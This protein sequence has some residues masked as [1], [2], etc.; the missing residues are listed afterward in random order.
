[1]TDHQRE[2]AYEWSGIMPPPGSRFP[3]DAH[4]RISAEIDD[5]DP[6]LHKWLGWARRRLPQELLWLIHPPGSDSQR[7][8]KSWFI[9]FGVIPPSAFVA[10]DEVSELTPAPAVEQA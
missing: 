9:Y 2:Q 7:Q 4:V 1:M 10:I 6:E 8:A 3:K 5:D